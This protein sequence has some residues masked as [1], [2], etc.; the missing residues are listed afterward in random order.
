MIKMIKEFFALP[1][2][3]EDTKEINFYDLKLYF[4]D[5]SIFLEEKN[6]R[7]VHWDRN[8]YIVYDKDNNFKIRFHKGNNM[9]LVMSNKTVKVLLDEK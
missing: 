3:S 6:V 8:I 7:V 4:E 9:L 5:G 2:T 1:D